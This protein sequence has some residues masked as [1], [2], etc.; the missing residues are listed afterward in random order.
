MVHLYVMRHALCFMFHEWNIYGS[1]ACFT[2]INVP[3]MLFF[4]GFDMTCG[5]ADGAVFDSAKVSR[6]EVPSDRDLIGTS[7]KVDL[8]IPIM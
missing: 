6:Q 2:C 1:S 7:D 8:V 3:Y 4:I 5:N